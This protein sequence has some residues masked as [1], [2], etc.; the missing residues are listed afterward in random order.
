VQT[1][2]SRDY[3]HNQPDGSDTTSFLEENVVMMLYGGR[4]SSGRCRVSSLSPGAPTHYSWGHDGLR[5]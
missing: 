2:P 3:D 5:V 1:L 4:P